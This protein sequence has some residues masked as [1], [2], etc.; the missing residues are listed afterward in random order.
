MKILNIIIF[1]I[2]FIILIT[3]N[4]YLLQKKIETFYET[5]LDQEQ[6]ENI[7]VLEVNYDDMTNTLGDVIDESN[8]ALSEFNDN[9]SEMQKLFLE[10]KE[11]LDIIK[12]F[13]E[14]EKQERIKQEKERIEREKRMVKYGDYIRIKHPEKLYK[15]NKRKCLT[16]FIYRGQHYSTFKRCNHQSIFQIIDQEEKKT[17]TPVKYDDEFF[18]RTVNGPKRTLQNNHKSW[19]NFTNNNTDKW[20]KFQFIKRGNPTENEVYKNKFL[21]IKSVKTNRFMQ[22]W[23][24]NPNWRPFGY[25]EPTPYGRREYWKRFY[26]I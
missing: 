26:V 16:R 1:F 15:S 5:I 4:S 22:L 9:L 21:Y 6:N 20:E 14:K 10:S 7:N 13:T 3:I 11:F 18:L 2:I 17:G 8:D 12:D 25:R 23:G 24:G 19:G